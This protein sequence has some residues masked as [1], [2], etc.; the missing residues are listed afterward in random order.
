MKNKEME[1]QLEQNEVIDVNTIGDR[2][3]G[4]EGVWELYDF[5]DEVSYC[6]AEG[7]RW[8]ISIGRRKLDGKIFAATD[9]R[10]YENP[11]FECLWMR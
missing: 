5:M 2:W 7:E 11:A 3:P 1:R 8:I 4:F 10:F 9:N 6:D